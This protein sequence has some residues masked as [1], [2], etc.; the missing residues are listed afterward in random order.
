M[1]PAPAEDG[2]DSGEN[3]GDGFEDTADVDEL[4]E[5]APTG[6]AAAAGTD[7]P[8]PEGVWS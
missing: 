7:G 8:G 6:G 1:I 5:E 2:A 3:G 4:E